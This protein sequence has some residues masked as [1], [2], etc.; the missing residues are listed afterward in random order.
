MGVRFRRVKSL[1]FL[2]QTRRPNGFSP[3]SL[4]CAPV[5]LQTTQSSFIWQAM[6]RCT[7]T[8]LY[9][10]LVLLIRVSG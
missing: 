8:R 4:P 6:V 1:E 2:M 7:M 10:S 9:F 3:N 5:E